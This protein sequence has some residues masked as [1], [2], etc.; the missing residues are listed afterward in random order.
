M[1]CGKGWEK[2]RPRKEREK[3]QDVDGEWA[4]GRETCD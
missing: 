2:Y 4:Q 1:E 3:G